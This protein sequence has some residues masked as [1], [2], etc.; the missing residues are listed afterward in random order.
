MYHSSLHAGSPPYTA[1]PS[2][3][4]SPPLLGMSTLKRHQ[5]SHLTLCEKVSLPPF[6]T[7]PLGLPV[8]KQHDAWNFIK[9][10]GE[11]HPRGKWDWGFVGIKGGDWGWTQ[12]EEQQKIKQVRGWLGTAER[13]THKE[14]K[15]ECTW[16]RE[17]DIVTEVAVRAHWLI[18]APA[19]L[20][21]WY[22]LITDLQ[23]TMGATKQP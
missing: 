19:R 9:M 13:Q 11:M 8:F 2:N 12:K 7:H 10:R 23:C 18:S 14:L 6:Q 22:V 3:I 15:R 21:S 17:E 4:L 5:S 16:N 1:G 20:H